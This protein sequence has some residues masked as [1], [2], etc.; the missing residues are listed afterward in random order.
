MIQVVCEYSKEHKLLGKP[1]YQ[2]MKQHSLTATL[3]SADGQ[4]ASAPEEKH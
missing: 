2:G 3:L 4:P 1:R